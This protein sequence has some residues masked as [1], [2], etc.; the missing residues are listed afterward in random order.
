MDVGW[1]GDRD[2]N[3]ALACAVRA[4]LGGVHF[5]FEDCINLFLG[6]YC[7]HARYSNKLHL[8]LRGAVV[9]GT[10]LRAGPNGSNRPN[11]YRRSKRDRSGQGG[12]VYRR[13][14]HLKIDSQGETGQRE[15]LITTST[16]QRGGREGA[17]GGNGQKKDE[18]TTTQS[19]LPFKNSLGQSTFSR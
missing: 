9:P 12:N 18:G 10:Y 5:A 13:K 11:R 7:Q 16:Q 8:N 3:I 4:A 19:R 6:I 1:L 14:L 2:D 15:H 17:E